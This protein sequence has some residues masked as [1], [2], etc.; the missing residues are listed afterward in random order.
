MGLVGLTGIAAGVLGAALNLRASRP[1]AAYWAAVAL[2]GLTEALLLMRRQAVKA[3]EPFWSP[4]TRRVAQAVAPAFFMGLVVGFFFFVINL[5][6]TVG[7][8]AL[9]V[10]WMAFYGLALHA[11]GFFM[12]RGFRLFGWVFILCAAAV[13]GCLLSFEHPGG[14]CLGEP[15]HRHG[16]FVRRR[17]RG[18]WAL[19]L[20]HGKAAE[21]GVNSPAHFCAGR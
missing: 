7:V 11:A 20:L 18:L 2:V 9:P 4:P 12:P 3:L 6:D 10:L 14:P 16:R 1:V 15:Q 21:R 8:L 5:H 13:L 19:S 17:A